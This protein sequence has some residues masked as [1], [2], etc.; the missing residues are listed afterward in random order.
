[1]TS[2]NQTPEDTSSRHLWLVNY[3]QRTSPNTIALGYPLLAWSFSS[4]SGILLQAVI[5]SKI[6]LQRG[7]FRHETFRPLFRRPAPFPLVL[8]CSCPLIGVD[9]EIS[10]IVQET[11]H[12]IF[13]LAPHTARAPHQFSEYHA[14]GSL[15]FSTRATNPANKICV[16]SPRCSRFLP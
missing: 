11:H 3:G 12:P 2:A 13:S 6:F 9:T 10:E 5:H 4:R 16:K 7:Q 8:G 1:M 14:F 15:A